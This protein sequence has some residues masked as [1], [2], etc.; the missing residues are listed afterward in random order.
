[1]TYVRVAELIGVVELV[2]DQCNT[3]S[4]YNLTLRTLRTGRRQTPSCST[5]DPLVE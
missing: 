2:Y 3:I 5:R 1:M 4:Y